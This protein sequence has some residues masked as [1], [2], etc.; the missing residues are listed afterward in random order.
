MYIYVGTIERTPVRKIKNRL[1]M[2][3]ADKYLIENLN[4]IIQNGFWDENS[5]PKYLDGIEAKT[6][7]I[8]QVYEKYDISKEN[9]L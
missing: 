6:K 1:K 8:V 7:F 4:E 3:K 5:R 9:S 2:I